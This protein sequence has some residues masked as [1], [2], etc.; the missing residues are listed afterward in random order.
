MVLRAYARAKINLAIDVLGKRQDNYHQVAMVLQSL[1]LSDFLYFQK[2]KEGITFTCSDPVLGNSENNLVYRAA[3]LMQQAAPGT[4]PGVRIHL[5][6]KIPLA[7]GLGGGSAD[8]AATLVA[9]NKLW[10][11]ELKQ[12]ELVGLGLRLGADVPFCLIGGTA[13]VEGMGERVYPLPGLPVLPVVL[14]KPPFG[15]STAEVYR[16][17]SLEEPGPRPD[18]GILKEAI[19]KGAWQEIW[20]NA[21][22]VLEKGVA[23]GYLAEIKRLKETLR[24]LGGRGVA[25]SGSG[26]TVFGFFPEA[27]EAEAAATRLQKLGYWSVATKTCSVGVSSENKRG[28]R[29]K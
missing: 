20:D 26:P 7:A 28:C 15:L 6:K 23:P 21:V 18:M 29:K 19:Y 27:K 2:N 9:L 11:L 10:G 14:A 17:I 22:N 16:R 3:V 24:R 13:L 25:M 5:E 4:V 12:G 1:E 8:A